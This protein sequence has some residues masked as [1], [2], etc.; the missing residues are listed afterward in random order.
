MA[1]SQGPAKIHI[2][3]DTH[4]PGRAWICHSNNLHPLNPRLGRQPVPLS[5]YSTRQ[6]HLLSQDRTQS[7]PLLLISSVSHTH[8]DSGL[9]PCSLLLKLSH[10][11]T[12]PKSPDPPLA[13]PGLH[14]AK[15]VM[16]EVMEV[17]TWMWLCCL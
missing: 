7:R 11:R 3:R 9:L 10:S 8:P 16:P 15:T 2:P 13:S 1:R 6:S 4:K 12:S 5:V 14:M 17:T